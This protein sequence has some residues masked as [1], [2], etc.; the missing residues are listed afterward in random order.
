MKSKKFTVPGFYAGIGLV[1]R[2]SA[3]QQRLLAK[4]YNYF[5]LHLI[6]LH[7]YQDLLSIACVI[8]TLICILTQEV[9]RNYHATLEPNGYDVAR[10]VKLSSKRNCPNN[11]CRLDS[12]SAGRL[13]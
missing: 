2:V 8:D 10:T 1:V 4:K 6:N 9:D 12:I 3:P 13:G 5:Q 11:E 7:C